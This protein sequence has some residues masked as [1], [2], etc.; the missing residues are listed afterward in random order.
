MG[1]MDKLARAAAT[2]LD[3]MKQHGSRAARSGG[4]DDIARRFGGP[5]RGQKNSGWPDAPL[6][7]GGGSQGHYS[8]MAPRS[9]DYQGMPGV[10]QTAGVKPGVLS[11][12]ASPPKIATPWPSKP[13]Q[14]EYAQGPHQPLSSQNWGGYDAPMAPGFRDASPTSQ[15]YDPA[16]G[17]SPPPT[18][19]RRHGPFRRGAKATPPRVPNEKAASSVSGEPMYRPGHPKRPGHGVLRPGESGKTGQPMYKPGYKPGSSP[20][21]TPGGGTSAG[22]TL[23]F[24][25]AGLAG[26]AALGAGSSYM[27]GGNV[28]QGAVMGAVTGGA[29]AFGGAKLGMMGMGGAAKMAG[30]DAAGGFSTGITNTMKNMD[31]AAG[32][33]MMFAGGGLLG[34][35]AFGGRRSHRRGFNR[36]RGNT[37]GR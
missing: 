15:A 23:G 20:G 33:G 8:P 13:R 37:I 27:T 6:S 19:G 32:R 35:M 16:R 9:P 28:G 14:P 10:N 11:S 29:L 21:G 12:S 3:G 34:G 2:G 18:S 36:N 31:T 4:M 1:V 5:K 24:G 30:A 17:V 22:M 25:A 7:V 26:G